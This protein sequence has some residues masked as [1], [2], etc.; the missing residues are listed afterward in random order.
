MINSR[1]PIL[2]TCVPTSLVPTPEDKSTS[3]TK[4]NDLP[5]SGHAEPFYSMISTIKYTFYGTCRF[6]I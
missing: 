5:A 1:S 3:P 4:I 2:D 6:L